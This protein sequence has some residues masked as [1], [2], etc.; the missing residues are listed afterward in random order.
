MEPLGVSHL[1]PLQ[2]PPHLEP[3]PLFG[4]EQSGGPED[5]AEELRDFVG[6]VRDSIEQTGSVEQSGKES[7]L[8][9]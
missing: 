1:L 3:V 2:K 9:G 5:E 7:S 6:E 8:N 4:V